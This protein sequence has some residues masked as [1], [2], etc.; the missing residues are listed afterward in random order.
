MNLDRNREAS[1]MQLYSDYIHP[2][3]GVVSGIF[4][5]AIMDVKEGVHADY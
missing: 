3:N 4:F 2:R 5:A 1:H